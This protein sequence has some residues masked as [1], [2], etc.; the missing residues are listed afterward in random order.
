MLDGIRV[1]DLSRFIAGPMCAMLLGDLG[2]DVI[3]VERLGGEDSRRNLPAYKGK[4]I[5]TALYNRNKRAI[6][7]DLK[8][9]E[10]KA[11][12]RRL[13]AV[14]DIVVENFRPGTMAKLGLAYDD[15]T[16]I[17]PDIIFVSISGFGQYG[18]YKDRVLF[19]CIAQARSGLMYMNGT[20]GD[21]PQLTK[22]MPADSLAAVYG[23][24][25]AV[26]ALLHRNRTGK[27]QLIDLA[28]FDALV[29]A[30]GNALP[31]YASVGVEPRR[32]GNSD[33]TNAPGGLFETAD[34]YVYLHAGT[35]AFWERLCLD[36]LERGSLLEREDLQTPAQ[37][38][39]HREEIEKI[40]AD[41]AIQ[42]RADEVEA[43][44]V[45]AGVPCAAVADIPRATRDPQLAARNML[46][47]VVDSEGD[48]VHVLGNP[49]KFSATPVDVRVPP[50]R[51]SEHTGEVLSELLHMDKGEVENLR[52]LGVL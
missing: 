43:A 46:L 47:E 27:G 8:K 6:A 17:R 45:R 1:L 44:C 18:P 37:R 49:L 16:K 14:S 31:A 24:L 36:V 2:A 5:Y 34:A 20:K 52:E 9:E 21:P 10:G 35:P 38:L 11:V 3:K 50:P 28:V 33:E 48:M 19:D 26:S 12:L 40:V 15:M 51:V 39:E 42:R 13:V 23:A 22:M 4:S 32:L 29:S 7:L 25:G 30:L 41:W